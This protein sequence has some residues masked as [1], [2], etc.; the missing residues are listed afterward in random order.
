MMVNDQFKTRQ[1]AQIENICI[2]P[3]FIGWEM[4]VLF[5]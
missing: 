1:T 4:I 3:N 2:K 5:D